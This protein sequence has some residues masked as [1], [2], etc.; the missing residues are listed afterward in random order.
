MS[1]LTFD[2][3]SFTWP[4]GTAALTEVSGSFSAGRTG[5]V[6]RNGSGKS[7][8]L[9]L[10]SGK[11]QPTDGTII[12]DGTDLA[13][14]TVA[15]L[16]QTITAAADAR[17]SELLGVSAAL[18]AVRAVTAGDVSDAHFEAIGDDWDIEARSHAALAAVGLAPT[19]LDRTVGELSGGEA[20]L[21]ALTGIRMQRAAITLLDEPTNNLDRAAR[22]A[23]YNLVAAWRGTLIV[24]SH[25]ATLLNLMDETAELYDGSITTFGGPYDAWRD[26]LE[27]QQ[28]AARAAASEARKSLTHEKQQR[29]DAET[30]LARRA[31]YARNDFENKRRPRMI[32]KLR[33]QEAQVSAGKLRGQA[34]QKELLARSSLADAEAVVRADTSLHIELPDPQI[35]ASR[36]IAELGD[37]NHTWVL[38]GA[39]T[40]AL[41]GANGSGKTTLLS[42]LLG[43]EQLAAHPATGDRVRSASRLHTERVAH[44]AQSVSGEDDS[45]T[46]YEAVKSV[47]PHMPDREVTN[48][49]ARFLLRGDKAHRRLADLSGG[50]RFRVSLARMLLADPTPE[51]LVFDEP[52]NNLDLETVDQLLDALAAYRGAVIVVSHDDDFLRRLH[53]HLV[54]ELN[55][56]ALTALTFDES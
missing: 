42:H 14:S 19:M 54:L 33:G 34:Q 47:A 32:M 8:L 30:K 46:A 18:D 29:I 20:M 13:G 36:R 35:S 38:Q 44:I 40:V 28:Q 1:T 52:T 41:V 2:R 3:V 27:I 11:L 55:D 22:A 15:Y 48:Q 43:Q 6:G 26:W 45:V 50:E 17:V 4:D 16:P 9:R 10:A 7:T 37:G 51:L 25:D 21:A 23:V 5:L 39:E 53:P 12:A 49:L 24:V 31:R 56:D